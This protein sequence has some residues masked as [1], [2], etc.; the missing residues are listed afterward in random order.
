M[1]ADF[2]DL[3]SAFDEREVEYVLLGG[4]A[5]G[6]HGLRRATG[7]LDLLVRATPENADRIIE[8]LDSYGGPPHIRR[9]SFLPSDEEPP[10]GVWF[11]REPLRVDLLTS[12]SGLSWDEAFAD[13]AMLE[14]AGV[15]VRVL[16]VRALLKCKRA[17]GR[18]KDLG[19]IAFLEDLLARG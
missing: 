18:P 2:L 10:T 8:A 6:F 16:G 5:L 15:S 14:T 3:L 7:D 9:E 1:D 11:G 19:D 12:V 4:Y 17:A 13:S